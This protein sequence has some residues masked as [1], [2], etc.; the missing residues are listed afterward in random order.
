MPI[1][2][3]IQNVTVPRSIEMTWGVMQPVFA[4]NETA[5]DTTLFLVGFT[6][7]TEWLAEYNYT[8]AA[9]DRYLLQWDLYWA[10][11]VETCTEPASWVGSGVVGGTLMFSIQTA[12]RNG[13]SGRQSKVHDVQEAI[14]ECPEFGG[15]VQVG[16]SLNA[17]E[18]EC[19]ALELLEARQGNPCA[20]KVDQAAASSISSRVSRSV[21]SYVSMNHLAPTATA[22]SLTSKAGVG[23]VRTVQTALAA[24][25]VLCGLAL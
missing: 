8:R 5:A 25:C 14:P 9:D 13:E 20:I 2:F 24:A 4:S 3:A 23:P 19:P 16:P 15:L 12:G 17:T 10:N 22:S 7:V 21:S 1:V 6:N 18:P 11:L